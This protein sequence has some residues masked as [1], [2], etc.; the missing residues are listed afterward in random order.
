MTTLKKYE[1]GTVISKERGKFDEWCIYINGRAPFDKEYFQKLFDLAQKHRVDK[2]YQDFMTL[3]NSTTD[4]IDNTIFEQLIPDISTTYGTDAGD[5]EE[6]FGTFYAV[7]LAEENRFFGRTRTK[8]GRRVKGLAAYQILFEGFSI[9]N[10][11]NFSKGKD[12]ED[13]AILCDER[14]LQR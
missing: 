13:L 11:C 10:A 3:Y 2:V 12:W 6:L 7:M 1:S 8:L 5:V 14:D 9:E 4:E